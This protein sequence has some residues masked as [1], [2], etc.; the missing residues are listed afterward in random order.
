[1]VLVDLNILGDSS[2]GLGALGFSASSFFIQ[3]ITFLLAYLVLRK[4]AFGPI[5]KVL[6]ERRETIAKGVTLGEQMQKEKADFESKVADM[7]AEARAKA[8]AIIADANEDGKEVIRRAEAKAE[9]KAEAI[10][11]EAKEQ[12]T[13]E[14]N[15]ARRK[16]E[17][18]I[19]DLIA[20][21]TE[22]IT[23]EKVDSKKDADLINRALA[24]GARK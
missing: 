12:T 6:R 7:I 2:S 3:L 20:E 8:D 19:I 11:S 10:V 9:A 5:L 22:V 23:G 15:R 4:W 24:Q 13:Q 16:L 21:A 14:M 1:V 18:E 17:A